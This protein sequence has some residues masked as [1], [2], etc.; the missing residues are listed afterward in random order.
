MKGFSFDPW[1]LLLF[2]L[3]AVLLLTRLDNGCLWQDE[4]ET[5]VLGK[6][7][8]RF[9]YPKGDDGGNRLNPSWPLASGGAWTYHT[10]LSM[11]LAALSFLVLGT[12]TFAARL[13]FALL[14]LASIWLAYRLVRRLLGNQ[15]LAR[16]TAFLLLTCVPFLLHMRQC[17]YYA[18]TIFFG[19][20][21]VWAY[22]RFLKERRGSRWELGLA[23]V[24][25][26]HTNQ[27]ALPPVAAA[28]LL[29]LA[30]LRAPRRKWAALLP[31]GIFVLACTAPFAL[32]LQ[33]G[34]LQGDLS[35][36]QIRH[37]AQFYFRQINKY[38]LP[39]PFWLLLLAFIP[40][41][42][43]RFA[44]LMG[45]RPDKPAWL[46]AC[47]L[48][49][50]LLFLI[51]VPEQ[52][53]F[54]YLV[55]LIPWLM[56]FQATLLLSVFGTWR[57]AG[58]IL[59][60]VILLTDLVH[61]SGVNVLAAQIPSVRQRLSSP[62]ARIRSL[63]LEYLGEI[64]RRYRG[65]MD[66]V[67]EKLTA[68]AQPGQTIKIPYEDHVILFYTDLIVEPIVDPEDFLRP[69]FPDWVVLRRDWLPEG[70]EQSEYFR[71][72]Q[73]RYEKR[74]LDAPDIPWQ[75]RPDPGYHRFL[76]DRQAPPVV[77]FRKRR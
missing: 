59:A 13:P 49:V 38:L 26:F 21:A 68:E 31:V 41:L 72:I 58:Y 19:L 76:T 62:E 6:S 61:Y 11:Y 2:C 35:W 74:V 56:L 77:L 39:I 10:W 14:G 67:V 3:A 18:P 50:G 43:R 8:L 51:L 71:Q 22:L 64:T 42:R 53:H 16:W 17:R 9:G 34:Q 12:T 33:M 40:A 28:L 55:N 66:A 37:H 25:L 36:N 60:A 70:F 54:R 32:W 44:V 57:A 75:N 20:W 73:S 4:A 30:I 5:A 48:A 1:L 29:H 45:A 27:G 23:A 69:T 24:L 47:L 46:A 63:P 15:S 65:P 52:R 7:I